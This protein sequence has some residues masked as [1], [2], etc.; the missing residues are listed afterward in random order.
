MREFRG[1][2]GHDIEWLGALYRRHAG[3]SIPAAVTRYL[4]RMASWS[5]DLRYVTGAF[6]SEEAEQFMETVVAIVTWAD[7]RM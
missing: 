3:A 5:T 2:R 7:G 6:K 4:A 1:Q